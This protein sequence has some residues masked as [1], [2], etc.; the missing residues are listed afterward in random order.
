METQAEYATQEPPKPPQRPHLYLLDEHVH[1]FYPTLAARIGLNEAIVV[2]QIHSWIITYTKDA[3]RFSDKHWRD[4]AWWI[5]NSYPEWHEALPYLSES[6][7]KRTLHNLRE[8]GI[9]KTA[10][11]NTLKIDRTLWYT[12]DYAA[13]DRLW[14]NQEAKTDRPSDQNDQMEKVNLASPLPSSSPSFSS[15]RE[16]ATAP[17]APDAS[18]PEEPSRRERAPSTKARLPE[19]SDPLVMAAHCAGAQRVEGQWTTPRHKGLS[20]ACSTFKEATGY[21]PPGPWREKIDEYVGD[22]PAELKR[23]Y[24]TCFAYVGCGWSPRNA[25]GMLDFY[26]LDQIPTTKP[27]RGSGGASGPRTLPNGFRAMPK[28]ARPNDRRAI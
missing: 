8:M 22:T 5:W 23:W 7:V 25:K 18:W 24:D 15:S 10:N 2:Q 6:T 19:T 12:I 27:E 14:S 1:S 13:Y 20:P 3:K 17:P 11:Y 16:G 9:V 21:A 28:T 26:V 4:G